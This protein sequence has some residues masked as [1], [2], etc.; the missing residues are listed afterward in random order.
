MGL[1][2]LKDLWNR[3]SERLPALIPARLYGARKVYANPAS[4]KNKLDDIVEERNRRAHG[5]TGAAKTRQEI[6][7]QVDFLEHFSRALQQ[8]VMA[9]LRGI[10][11]SSKP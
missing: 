3:I 9:H 10:R 5:R 11:K 4:I 7:E 8:A 2:G 1:I 6:E